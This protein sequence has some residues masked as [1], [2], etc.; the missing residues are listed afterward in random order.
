MKLYSLLSVIALLGAVA[1]AHAQT[2]T[3]E[4]AKDAPDKGLK[5]IWGGGDPKSSVYSSVYVPHIQK[6]LA[7]E[8]LAGYEWGGVTQ[9][10]LDNAERITENPTHIAV[11]QWDILRQLNGQPVEGKTETYKF[12]VIHNNIGPECLYAVI[13]Q[14]GYSL[15]GHV[16]GNS[17]D[18]AVITGGRKSGSRGSWEILKTVFPELGD[19]PVTEAGGA[20][21]IVKQAAGTPSSIGFFVMRPDPNSEVFQAIADL[22]LR[23]V[24]IVDEKLSGSYD[25]FDLKVAHGGVLFGE[26]RSITTACTSVAL[27]TGDPAALDA[28]KDGVRTLRRLQATIERAKGVSPADWKPDIDSWRDMWDSM[29]TAAGEKTKELMESSKQAL[30]DIIKK[31]QQ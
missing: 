24:P 26:S 9:G 3:A 21:D 22:N 5:V 2:L 11:G 23:F 19:M 31:E 16:I 20:M 8:R 10:T 28:D 17:W 15:W 12:T 29:K 14:D 30:Q 6:V 25:F 7:R 13:N 27:I 18:L 1:P 4:P